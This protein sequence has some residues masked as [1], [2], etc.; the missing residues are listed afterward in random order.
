MQQTVNIY[1]QIVKI[2]TSLDTGYSR[3]PIFQNNMCGR[4][5]SHIY[6]CKFNK[7]I[8]DDFTISNPW[9]PSLISAGF[10]VYS[11]QT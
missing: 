8:R 3:C 1:V 7:R 11:D 10:I 6:T 9:I 4:Y 5:E 2:Q